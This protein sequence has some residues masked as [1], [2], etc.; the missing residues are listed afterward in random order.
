MERGL[1]CRPGT[2]E[3]QAL[4]APARPE[5][6]K[7]LG[8]SSHKS[9]ITHGAVP[10]GSCRHCYVQQ[11]ADLWYYWAEEESGLPYFLR[12]CCEG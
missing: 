3:T 11:A 6:G 10:K 1:R 8:L 9:F 2:W 4:D 7:G 12:M 5:Y